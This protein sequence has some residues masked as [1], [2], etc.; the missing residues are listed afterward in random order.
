MSIARRRLLVAM[1]FGAANY[2]LLR[3]LPAD[4]PTSTTPRNDDQ[5]AAA[6]SD[7]TEANADSS[8]P[9]PQQPP[10]VDA[11]KAADSTNEVFDL[12][13]TGGRV[14]D[15]ASGF[16][17]IANVGVSGTSVSAI[18]PDS[19]SLGRATTTIDATGMVVA[20]GFID[21]LSYSPNGYGEWYKIADGVTTNLGMHGLSRQASRWFAS[22]PD[23][24]APLHF[25]G[26]YDNAYVRHYLHGLDPFDSASPEVV[27]AI[28]NDARS[29]LEDGFVGLHM[30]PEY[31]PG[32]ETEELL[33]H[34]RLA[35][36]QEVPLC[37]HARYSDNLPPG[38]NLE[39]IDE[40]VNAARE[41]GA[42]LHVEHIGSTGGTGVM[43]EALGR[44]DAANAEGLNMTAC[45][46]P[47]D[48]WASNIRSARFD[49]WQ[50]K[51]NL[52]FSD[53][54]VIGATERLTEANFAEAYDSNRLT[55]AFNIPPEDVELALQT[56][57][58]MVGSDAI[59]EPS[60]Q[61]HPR[62]TGCFS[63]VL[64]RYVRERGVLDL[65]SALSKMTI[66]PAR[67][68]ER[69]CP[70]L[71]SKGR[72]GI[73]SDA[74]ITVFDPATVI[75]RS[76]ITNPAQESVGIMWVI[77]EGQIMR[78]PDGNLPAGPALPGRGM[79]S[80]ISATTVG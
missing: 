64:G 80:D 22:Y 52:T 43:A 11:T 41:T 44:I 37:V 38:T 27:E 69:R 39:A 36:A 53:L 33:A 15:P 46:Y 72:L 40:L 60:H 30:E 54:Q 32:A 5:S 18:A 62:S 49:D 74:D 23:G 59:L 79:R 65:V 68:L 9:V 26:A 12:V 47:Y 57:F 28:V 19:E 13:I 63:R 8:T 7:E 3:N 75:D 42:S 55:A 21:I 51:F 67:L 2:G 14:V 34:A 31:T 10:V 76:T 29:D 73:G 56:D 50:R 48:F 70:S 16:D 61:N 6:T 58:V 78:S 25:G 66:Q 71:R 4:T 24:S 77:V 20:P 17:Q 35:A 45:V 1:G